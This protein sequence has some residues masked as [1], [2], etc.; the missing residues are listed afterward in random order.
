MS[1][2]K[3]LIVLSFFRDVAVLTQTSLSASRR[4]C[5]GTVICSL[6]VMNTLL[7]YISLTLV[8]QEEKKSKSAF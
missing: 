7:E 4:V 1:S 6:E 2:R 5:P 3:T 8:Y